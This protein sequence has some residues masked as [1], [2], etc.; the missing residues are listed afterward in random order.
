MRF[1][2]ERILEGVRYALSQYYTV[3]T[4]SKSRVQVVPNV[5][6]VIHDVQMGMW[7]DGSAWAL[8]GLD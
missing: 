6:K 2:V 4:L 3:F 1:V 8:N 5:V 7:A